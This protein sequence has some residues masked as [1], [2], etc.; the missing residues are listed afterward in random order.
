[1]TPATTIVQEAISNAVSNLL[2]R[3]GLEVISAPAGTGTSYHVEQICRGAPNRCGLVT[4]PDGGVHKAITAVVYTV[5]PDL[6][7]QQRPLFA[8]KDVVYLEAMPNLRKSDGPTWLRLALTRW[9]ENRSMESPAL[10]FLDGMQKLRTPTAIDAFIETFDNARE[11]LPIS[12]L[13]LGNERF[14]LPPD[15]AAI[16]IGRSRAGW[17]IVTTRD[18]IDHGVSIPSNVLDGSDAAAI[19]LQLGASK[20]LARDIQFLHEHRRMAPSFRNIK[21]ILS[22]AVGSDGEL[23]DAKIDAVI[24]LPASTHRLSRKRMTSSTATG[25]SRATI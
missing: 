24:D 1:M 4:I 11:N 19:A 15:L 6:F 22:D 18:R 21:R 14:R 7:P 2:V 8:S 10:L 3:Q 5:A 13:L 17:S 23:D 20:S 12:A 16:P 9:C 25:C